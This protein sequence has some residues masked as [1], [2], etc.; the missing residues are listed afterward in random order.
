LKIAHLKISD[1][2]M[3]NHPANPGGG[4]Y[5]GAPH[6]RT[7]HFV[8]CFDNVDKRFVHLPLQNASFRH[9]EYMTFH[10]LKPTGTGRGIS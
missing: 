10:H 2:K 1:M 4:R 5:G 7:R 3:Y 6:A 9:V 8:I